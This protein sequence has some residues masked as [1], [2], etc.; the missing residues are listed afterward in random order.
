[1][2]GAGLS[3]VNQADRYHQG[4]EE[5]FRF[6]AEFPNAARLRTETAPPVRVTWVAAAESS[7]G[8]DHSR[9]S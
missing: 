5:T 8:L 4:L 2:T 7:F 6:L 9:S 1:V 3:G